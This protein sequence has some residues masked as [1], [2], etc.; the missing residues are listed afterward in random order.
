MA[1]RIRNPQSS[2][3]SL[4]FP[5]R[6]VLPPGGGVV[7]PLTL[8]QVKGAIGEQAQGA[9]ELDEVPDL[10]GD[11][12]AMGLYSWKAL[13]TLGATLALDLGAARFFAGTLAAPCTI[14]ILPAAAA[15]HGAG[16]WNLR[17]KGTAANAVTWANADWTGS[18]PD[19]TNA[20]DWVITIMPDDEGNFKMS[21]LPF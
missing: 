15:P 5:F 10:V 3:L 12:Y 19:L 11:E 17:L 2:A 7:V 14:T 21:A 9:L 13:G 18:G 8:A 1:V 20:N 6:G 16:H 4:P